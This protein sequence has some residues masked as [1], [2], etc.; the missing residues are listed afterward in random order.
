MPSLIERLTTPPDVSQMAQRRP[1]MKP[2][3][4]GMRERIGS[5]LYDLAT[6]AG[7]SAQADRMRREGAILA[8]FLPVVGDAIAADDAGRAYGAGDYLGA[9]LAALGVMPI[10]GD[11][12]GKAAKKGIRAFHGSPH[13][14]DKFSMDKIGTGEGAQAYGHGLYFAEEPAVARD[15]RDALMYR[16][17]EDPE[18]TALGKQINDLYNSMN[19][20]A[21]RMP[22]QQAQKEYDRLE[23]LELLMQDGDPVAVAE[24]IASSPED[25][26]AEAVKWFN[27][28]V[29]P[30]FTRKGRMYEVNI[31]ADPD[32]FL[33]WDKPLSEQ[34]GAAAEYIQNMKDLGLYEPGLPNIEKPRNM[35]GDL[36][37]RTWKADGRPPTGP[38]SKYHAMVANELRRE[39][40]PGI[41]YLDQ[42]SRGAG[43]GSHNYVVFDD[44]LIEIVRKYGIAGALAAGLITREQGQQMQEQ[45]VI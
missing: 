6:G 5:A 45:G 18:M 30:S 37:G 11:V 7:L 15:Y 35:L 20:R 9:G 13:D 40:V 36:A 29:A 32:D 16:A 14:F 42:G 41:K 1:Q 31:N 33:D 28:Q 22:I 8:D 3:N 26:P 19:D 44:S 10:V 43:E 34:T 2:R 39:G 12:A 23:M 17:G 25:Y 38:D 21:A 4:P 24:R 27:K